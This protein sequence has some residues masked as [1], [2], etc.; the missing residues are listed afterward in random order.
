MTDFS[1]PAFGAILAFLILLAAG[2][3]LLAQPILTLLAV[4]LTLA[5]IG[6]GITRFSHRASLADLFTQKRQ[7][8]EQISKTEKRFLSRELDENAYHKIL[9]EKQKQLVFIESQIDIQ[10]GAQNSAHSDELQKITAKHRHRL[11]ELLDQK[12]MLVHEH[13][14]TEQ[15]YLGRELDEKAY[16]DLKS[17]QDAKLAELE[18]EITKIEGESATNQILSELKQKL[19]EVALN[20]QE[21]AKRKQDQIAEDLFEQKSS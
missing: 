7:L 19:S 10:S 8:V 3:W 13:H 2:F 12:T 4:L 20:E 1:K 5:W 17:V 21:K 6:I 18:F 14:L 15:K 9:S 16:F 11:K